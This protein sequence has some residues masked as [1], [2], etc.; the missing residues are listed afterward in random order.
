MQSMT[1]HHLPV[2]GILCCLTAG[3]ALRTSPSGHAQPPRADDPVAEITFVV[4]DTETTGLSSERDRIVEIGAIKLRNGRILARKSWL[5]KPDVPIPEHVQ[6][7]HGITPELVK[8]CPAAGRV[9]PEFLEFIRGALLLAHNARFDARFVSAEL[10]R[11]RIA[12][13]DNPLLDSLPLFRAWFPDAPNHK[14]EDLAGYLEVNA[15]PSHRALA[16]AQRIVEIFRKGIRELPGEPTL[17]DLTR[18]EGR[19]LLRF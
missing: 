19:P 17:A 12:A 13:P 3:C 15:G 9:L 1:H 16:D 4:F 8:D 11:N 6:K 5:I 10:S 2:L 7:I 18:R 14:L